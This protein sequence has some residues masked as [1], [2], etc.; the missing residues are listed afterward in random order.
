MQLKDT[1]TNMKKERVIRTHQR[2]TKSGKVTTVRQHT[3]KYDAT[4]KL[5][6]TKKKGFGGELKNRETLGDIYEDYDFTEEDF[7]E[8]YE[9]TNSDADKKVANVLRKILGRKAYNELNDLA[10]GNYRKGGAN[11]FFRK[12]VVSKTKVD[13]NKLM[14]KILGVESTGKV[15]NKVFGVGTAKLLDSH[16]NVIGV[17]L[18]TPNAIAH[19]MANYKRIAS[20]KGILGQE[21]RAHY[22]DRS[23]YAITDNYLGAHLKMK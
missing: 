20:A 18:D 8:W 17:T 16:G 10:A 11:S 4:D 21:Y 2:H 22:A 7:K 13:D 12:N 5:K 9:G 23:D 6:T 14:E 1:H 15:G 3:A 19:A